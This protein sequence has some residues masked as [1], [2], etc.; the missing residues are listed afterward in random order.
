MRFLGVTNAERWPDLAAVP[1]FVESGYPE[2][3]LNSW[4]GVAAPFLFPLVADAEGKITLTGS[5]AGLP[6]GTMLALQVVELSTC[7]VSDLVLETF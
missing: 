6:L 5:A 1:T 3:A 2:V 4:I 7:R